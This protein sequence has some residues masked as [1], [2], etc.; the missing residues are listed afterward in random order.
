MKLNHDCVRAVMLFI[1]ENSTYDYTIDPS[2][3][4]LKDFSIEEIIYACDK[5]SEAGYLNVNKVQ[6]IT[7]D[8]PTFKIHSITW[9]GHIFLDN[10]RDNKVWKTTK[11]I[12]SKFS[13][14]SL[15][16][17]GDIA[18]QVITNLIQKQLEM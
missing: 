16:L 14:V 8:L 2:K 13:S 10:I 5:L 7:S 18:S 11:G 3:I 6:F 15:N 9:E 4:E 12:I 1:E 17:I